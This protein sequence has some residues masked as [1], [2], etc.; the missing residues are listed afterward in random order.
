MQKS[1]VAI[2]NQRMKTLFP[3]DKRVQALVVL[4]K[5][6][7][8]RGTLNREEVDQ[9]TVEINK[10]RLNDDISVYLEE[11]REKA[12]QLFTFNQELH[13][14]NLPEGERRSKIAQENGELVTW[15]SERMF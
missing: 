9:F 14:S 6:I 2:L 15:F 12:E 3:I 10:N 5:N 7:L 8:E 1:E 13:Y 4:L 11:V